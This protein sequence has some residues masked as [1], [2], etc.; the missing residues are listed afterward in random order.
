[1]KVFI[2][3]N[4]WL[5]FL[6]ADVKEQYE[7]CLQFFLAVEEGKIRPYTSSLVFLEI[8]YVLSATY[9]IAKKEILK[10]I[11]TILQTRNLT[12]V[13]E[14]DFLKAWQYYTKLNV[15]LVDCLIV[16]Q[17]PEDIILCSFDQEFRKFEGIRLTTPAELIRGI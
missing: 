1:M 10:D 4:V 15:K 16:S 5:R 3:T 13:E 14:T 8:N 7:E 9:K 17:L 2:D 12:L 6:L 11:N